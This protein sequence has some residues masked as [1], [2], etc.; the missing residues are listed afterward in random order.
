MLAVEDGGDLAGDL[1]WGEVAGDAE[2]GGETELAVDG[3]AYLGGDADGG[4]FVGVLG[5]CLVVAGFFE[6][7]FASVA[8]FASVAAG[9]PDGLYGLAVGEAD[10]VALGAVDGF[11]G[12][13]DL[14]DGEGGDFFEGLDALLVEGLVEL[15]RAVLGEGELLRE[16]A[17]VF[18]GLAEEELRV[19]LWMRG[20]LFQS[21][22]GVVA[23]KAS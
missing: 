9:H 18:Q 17:E 3:A 12:L 1:A 22:V 16:G 20:H 21:T 5:A 4:S 10:E 13:D 7:G 2:L 14:G 19:G 15:G 11:G 23:Y 6:G 8:S